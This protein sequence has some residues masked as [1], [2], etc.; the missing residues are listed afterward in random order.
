MALAPGSHIGHYEIL[1]SLGAG[2]MGE[3][4]RALDSTLGRHVALK[5]LPQDLAHDPVRI[6]RF[7]REAR[8]VASLNHPHIVTIHSVEQDTETGAHF[9]TMELVEGASL[10]RQLP[11]DGMP[12]AKLLDLAW[13]LADALAAAHDR[14]IVHRDLKPG[15]VMLTAD[16][17]VK[18]L[19]FGLAKVNEPEAS[20]QSAET[21]ARTREGVVMGTVPYMSPEQVEGRG[22]DARSDVFSLGVVLHE[23]AT[24]SRPFQ[25]ASTAA[26]LSSILRDPPPPVG[27]RRRDLPGAFGRLIARCLE[28]DRDRRVQTAKDVRNEIEAT[29]REL[30]PGVRP[31]SGPSA[32]GTARDRRSII[33]LPF[34]NLSPDADNAYF[35]DGLTEELIADLAK[36]NAL[37]V[38]SRSSSMQ[39]KGTTKGV[40]AIGEELGVQYV[41]DGSV[42]KAGNSLRITAQLVDVATDAPLWSE[43][44]AGTIDD[45]FEVQERVS[46]EIVKALGVRLTS[47]EARRLA[48][49]PIAD[50]RAFG[51]YLQAR[52][53]LRRYAIPT[54]VALIE[55]AIRIE[56]ETPPLVAM[57]AWATLWQ[58]RLGIA[59]DQ[60][61]LDEAERVAQSLVA[62]RPDASYVHALLG[63]LKYERGHLLEA[64][65][66]FRRA[67][68][69]EPND[70][71]SLVMM[72]FTL[73]GAGQDDEAQALAPRLVQ[74]DPLSA[75]T[76][77][78]AGGPLWFVGR[79]AEGVPIMQRGLD[80]DPDSFIAHWCTGY[81]CAVAGRIDD[82]KAH[83]AALRRL[84]DGGPYTRQLLALI[85]GLEGRQAAA[86]EWL[87]PINIAILDPHQ[88]FH[89]AESFLVAGDLERGLELLERSNFG[90]HPYVYMAHHCRFLDPV[91]HTP[92]FQALLAQAKERT[93]A[94]RRATG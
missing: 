76:W 3:V 69:L 94:F 62:E 28:K 90:F 14:G 88:Q 73:V 37:S 35:S 9:L 56:G 18:V 42:R 33:V 52:Q 46:R 63:N 82:A 12:V 66:H 50:P 13:A 15:N 22:V 38:I 41:L 79:A 36:V 49:R 93:E 83:A 64:L 61:P 74:S 51:L 53:Q 47:E 34:T 11:A 48:D 17:R 25:G 71:D 10:D 39:L 72:T 6:D 23:A 80:V 30:T 65:R 54:A 16:G 43:K 45:V 75:A 21:I 2:G 89:L 29:R 84:F 32:A 60:S 87:A 20:A 92:R 40:R 44:Y 57:R 67:I 7:R 8:T 1:D 77:T 78:A 26:V 70:T 5:I 68:E 31:P 86:R 58:V 4:Y 85:D 59:P 24:G 55:D 81:A 91:R 19:D 27:A